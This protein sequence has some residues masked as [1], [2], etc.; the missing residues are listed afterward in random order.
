MTAHADER[1]IVEYEGNVIN[2]RVPDVLPPLAAA[3][4]FEMDI[5]FAERM[6]EV[7]YG[8]ADVPEEELDNFYLKAAV[9]LFRSGKLKRSWGTHLGQ[10]MYRMPDANS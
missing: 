8:N 2:M 7:K 9:E 1:L 6:W 3:S 10:Y 5:A 4:D